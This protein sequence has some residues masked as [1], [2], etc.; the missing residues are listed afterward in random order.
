MRACGRPSWCSLQRLGVAAKPG[1]DQSE[2]GFGLTGSWSRSATCP[3]VASPDISIFLVHSRN[4]DGKSWGHGRPGQRTAVP[5]KTFVCL[6]SAWPPPP[7][8]AWWSS[9]GGGGGRGW[10]ALGAIWNPRGRTEFGSVGGKQATLSLGLEIGPTLRRIARHKDWASFLDGT[11]M[12]KEGRGAVRATVVQLDSVVHS[13][14]LA[15]GSLGGT[16]FRFSGCGLVGVCW[17]QQTEMKLHKPAVHPG[18]ST[19]RCWQCWHWA[20]ALAGAGCEQRPELWRRGY[21]GWQ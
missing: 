2:S 12:D 3:I 5:S 1:F 21:S 11:V 17:P 20:L 7:G 13:R 10:L 4:E 18:R 6:S 9:G 14:T 16:V 8:A 15:A 19:P